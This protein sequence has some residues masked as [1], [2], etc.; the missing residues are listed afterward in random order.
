MKTSFTII[1][2]TVLL[3]TSLSSFATIKHPSEN[4]A[5][6]R[7]LSTYLETV[8]L[9]NFDYHKSLFA[10]D[11]EYRNSANNKAYNKKQ[12]VKFLK[13]TKDLKFDC[14]TTYEVLDECDQAC[15][16]K[17]VMQFKE[18][19]RIDYITLIQTDKGGWL[20]NKVMTTYM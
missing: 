15:V 16:G 13:D 14:T 11:Y 6:K 8:A 9:G 10:E 20:I 17:I 5:T 18:F 12:F 3:I 4:S 1:A 19:T 7:V 2:V